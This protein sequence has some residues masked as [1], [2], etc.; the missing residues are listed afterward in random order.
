MS[1]Y[2][3]CDIRGIYPEEISAEETY[4]IGRA[5]GTRYE[6]AALCVAGDVRIS[7]EELKESLIQG[8]LDSGITVIDVGTIATPMFYFAIEE[9][10][11]AGG[12]MVTA[13][14]NPAQYN[15][16]KMM[17]GNMPIT[18]REIQEIQRLVKR[19]KFVTGKGERIR[20]EIKES[21]RRFLEES[22]P[23]GNL[24]IVMDCCNGVTGLYYPQI[25]GQLGYQVVTL[26][27]EPDGRFPNRN[28]NPALYTCLGDLCKKVREEHADLGAAYDGDGDRVVFVDNQGRVLLSEE[29]FVL[30]IEDALSRQTGSVV[31]DQKSMSIVPR[32]VERYKG[33]AIMEKSGYGFIKKRFLENHSL[34]AGEISGHFFFGEIGRDD[35]LYATLKMCELL[36]RK[37]KSLA[38]MADALPKSCVSPEIRMFCLYETQDAL[39]KKARKFSVKYPIEE[40]DGIRVTFPHGWFLIRKSVTE[41]GITVRMEGETRQDLETMKQE[42]LEV[43]PELGGHEYFKKGQREG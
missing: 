38:Q 17:F 34:L 26:Y 27:Q 42:I 35:G 11:V 9:L 8:L 20:R 16:L 43:I 21:Y 6:N 41:Q 39:L 15:G 7:T 12:I 29:S 14:H 3:E 2:K 23:R 37:K 5:L 13:S 28:P 22:C 10:E 19:K 4:H 1:I 32:T 30:Y 31:Y 18:D 24:K 36:T 33:R 25:A 40:L